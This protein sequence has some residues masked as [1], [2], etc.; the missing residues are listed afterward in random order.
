LCLVD[1]CLRVSTPRL[2]QRGSALAYFPERHF[3]ATKLWGGQT[4]ETIPNPSRHTQ[5]DG[6]TAVI[7]R[8]RTEAN[9]TLVRNFKQVVTVELRFDRLDEFI[10]GDRYIQLLPKSVMGPHI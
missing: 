8:E 7:D 5:V 3:E 1:G 9:R 6:S 10:D 4:S 2:R